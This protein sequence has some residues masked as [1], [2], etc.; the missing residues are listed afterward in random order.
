MNSNTIAESVRILG[1]RYET[2]L[3]WLERWNDGG[4][5]GIKFKWGDGRPSKLTKEQLTI[6][7]RYNKSWIKN[8]K[9]NKKAYIG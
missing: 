5:E 6:K 8:Y 9:T 4:F 2:G 7:R 1:Y 3:R